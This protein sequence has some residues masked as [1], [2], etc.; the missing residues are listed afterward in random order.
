MPRPPCPSR[1]AKDTKLISGGL[2]L[3]ILGFIYLR[4][5]RKSRAQDRALASDGLMS[6][7]DAPLIFRVS[8]RAAS[9]RTSHT[10]SGSGQMYEKPAW[11]DDPQPVSPT[12]PYS[13]YLSSPASSSS[14]S[15]SSQGNFSLGSGSSSDHSHLPILSADGH[16]LPV[17]PPLHQSQEPTWTYG[18]SSPYDAYDQRGSGR[19]DESHQ[20]R[21]SLPQVPQ[22]AQVAQMG[23]VPRPSQ[24]VVGVYPEL[25]QDIGYSGVQGLYGYP[26]ER[27]HG[28]A[29]V[30]GYTYGR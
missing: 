12:A 13:P 20:S 25:E 14:H 26:E 5:L 21:R 16:L 17:S 18:A 2:T 15:H 22:V 7:L 19:S 29:P 23:Y 27:A 4:R 3:L 9:V 11:S 24:G 10:R 8:S 30:G 6:S 1:L 28:Y